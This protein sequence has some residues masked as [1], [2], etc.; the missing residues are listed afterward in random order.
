MISIEFDDKKFFNDMLNVIGYSKGF[1]EGIEKGKE[2]FYKAIANDGIQIF[3]EFVDQQARIDPYMY[4]HIYEWY[5]Q[6]SPDSRLFDV[7]Y[8]VSNGGLTFNGILTQSISVKNGSNVPFY[9]KAKI[10]ERGIPITINPTKKAL[11]FNV[12]SEEVFVSGPITIDHPGGTRVAGSF[13]NIFRIFF[14]QH[15]KQSVLDVTGITRYLSNPS[16]FKYNFSSAKVGGKAKGTEV[17]YNWI[18]NAGGLSV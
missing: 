6:G 8:I 1:L 18:T 10:M 2:E 12:G 17:G 9:N 11:K 3:K 4:H 5:K 15:F 13:E 14:E 7:E 16:T